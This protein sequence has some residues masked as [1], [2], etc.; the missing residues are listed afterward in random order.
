MKNL[1]LSGMFVIN[2]WSS[3][4]P[5]NTSF[6]FCC[7]KSDC[8][9][10]LCRLGKPDTPICWYPGGPLITK[11]YW[12]NDTC[13]TCTRSCTV[14][15]PFCRTTP[16]QKKEA[17]DLRRGVQVPALPQ[18]G[19]AGHAAP[20]LKAPEPLS[21]REAEGVCKNAREED[22]G[23]SEADHTKYAC[24]CAGGVLVHGSTEVSIACV[25][26]VLYCTL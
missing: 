13:S 12:D 6:Y 4:C 9:H 11:R 19:R 23:S 17:K 8:T 1:R 15:S 2:I 21:P 14:S 5:P 18:R 24:G 20:P 10:P 7:Y 16:H 3:G 25:S 22:Q 26:I